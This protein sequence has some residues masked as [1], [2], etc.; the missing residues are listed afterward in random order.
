LPKR[1]VFGSK[2]SFLCSFYH[3]FDIFDQ[4]PKLLLSRLRRGSGLLC[5]AIILYIY[6]YKVLSHYRANQSHAEGVTRAVWDFDQKYQK[7]D[8]RNIKMTFLSQ[9]QTFLANF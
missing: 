7:N 5:N 2:K 3:F 6:K 1:S 4:N 8:K 9:K